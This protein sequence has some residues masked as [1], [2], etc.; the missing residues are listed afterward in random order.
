MT[1]ILINIFSHLIFIFEIRKTISRLC[2]YF[3][4]T[5]LRINRININIYAI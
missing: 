4:I 5:E 3:I 1:A 2:Y